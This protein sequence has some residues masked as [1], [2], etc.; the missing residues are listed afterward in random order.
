MGMMS[1]TWIVAK[2]ACS[3]PRLMSFL[4]RIFFALLRRGGSVTTGVFGGG[5]RMSRSTKRS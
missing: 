3:L 4:V 1:E 5:T 2:S